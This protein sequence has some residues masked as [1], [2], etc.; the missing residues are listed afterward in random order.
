MARKEKPRSD[1]GPTVPRQELRALEELW[2]EI[3]KLAATVLES[4][5]RSVQ[6]LCEGRTDLAAAV[7]VEEK[8]IDR[9]EVR[10]EQEC[11]RILALFGPTASDLRRVVGALR[12]SGELERMADLA[13]TI[14]DRARKRSASADAPPIPP[15]LEG[16]AGQALGQ[17]RDSLEALA[18]TDVA[19]AQKVVTDDRAIERRRRAVQKELK[20]AIRQ[21]PERVD[22]WL[23]LINT[24]RNLERVADH[25]RHIA[26]AVIYVKEGEIVRH[27]GPG[28]PPSAPCS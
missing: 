9:W 11:M 7:K 8:A 26:E 20:Q 28:A 12:I 5:S 13:E 1:Q 18:N 2:S 24:A 17:A 21:D 25:A 15:Q 6:A 22:T 27:G 16:L 19:L 23:R 14:A 4:L 3:Q 10:I